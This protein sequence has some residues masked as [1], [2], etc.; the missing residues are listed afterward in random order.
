MTRHRSRT[1]RRQAGLTLIEIMVALA[2]TLILTAG[3]IHVYIGSSQ[4]YRTHDSLSRIQENGRYALNRMAREIRMI[5]FG[6]AA[7]GA[8]GVP[9]PVNTLNDDYEDHYEPPDADFTLRGHEADGE[10]WDPA[11]PAWLNGVN[12]APDAGH[13]VLTFLQTPLDAGPP[14]RITFM[15]SAEQQPGG[16][17]AANIHVSNTESLQKGDIIM[18]TDCDNAAVFQITNVNE[19][20]HAVVHNTGGSQEPGNK[21]SN[22]GANMTGGFFLPSQDP[23]AYFIHQPD[24]ADLPGLWRVVDDGNNPPQELVEGVE[25]IELRYGVDQD[26]DGGVDSY[27]DASDV[28]NW[29]EVIAVRLSLLLVGHEPNVTEGDQN[30]VFAGEQ[31]DTSDGHLRQVFSTTVG[32]RNRGL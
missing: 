3:V 15:P 31:V 9:D 13:D 23:G 8:G 22:L 28:N 16:G 32:V 10:S 2:V 5:G 1:A 21:T 6:T 27:E 20:S 19:K 30:L 4:T 26:G 18:A 11:L 29:Q 24:H 14:A 25:G 12:P 7:C 17:P